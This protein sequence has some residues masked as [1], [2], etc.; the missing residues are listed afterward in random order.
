MRDKTE[1]IKKPKCL[2][3]NKLILESG[4]KVKTVR[5]TVKLETGEYS[6]AEENKPVMMYAN[7]IKM[8][9]NPQQFFFLYLTVTARINIDSGDAAEYLAKATAL[10][11]PYI[12]LL[13]AKGIRITMN[14]LKLKHSRGYDE[15][16]NCNT[17]KLRGL[18]SCPIRFVISQF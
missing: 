11:F 5:R 4:N 3:Y 6:T 10:N 18:H 9:K 8:F 7:T 16:K 14:S 2:P 15:M 13:T 17:Q 12:R 1:V